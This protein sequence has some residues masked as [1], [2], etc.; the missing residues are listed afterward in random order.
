MFTPI[1]I[2]AVVG[3]AILIFGADKL[4]KL[5]RSAGQ[6]KK[7]FMVGQAEADVAAERA[8]DEAR[9]RAGSEGSTVEAATAPSGVGQT[10]IVPDP[11]TG[12]PGPTSIARPPQ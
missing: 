7:E 1:E 3:V 8:R 6:A 10:T 4:P 5:A 12:A 2:A 11:Q 9:R